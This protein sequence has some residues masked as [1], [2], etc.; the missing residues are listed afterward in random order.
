LTKLS[1]ENGV[2]FGPVQAGPVQPEE[3][4]RVGELAGG[5]C[6]RKNQLQIRKFFYVIKLE[7]QILFKN[8]V[9]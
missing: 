9:S 5:G 4:A 3:E 8:F 1:F 2:H 7:F 6:L